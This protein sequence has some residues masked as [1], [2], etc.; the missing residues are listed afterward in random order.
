MPRYLL[1]AGVV[2][3]PGLLAPYIDTP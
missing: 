3:H 2:D 1:P